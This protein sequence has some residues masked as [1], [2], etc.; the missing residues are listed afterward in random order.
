[1]SFFHISLVSIPGHKNHWS[2]SNFRTDFN[3]NFQL[4]HSSP[5]LVHLAD[6]NKYRPGPSR[7]RTQAAMTTHAQR[8]TCSA[9]LTLGAS[10]TV[11]NRALHR[12]YIST[13]YNYIT[14]VRF[15][16]IT[17]VLGHKKITP[18]GIIVENI[19]TNWILS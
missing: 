15:W 7:D 1:M 10:T 18:F 8:Q 17:I 6:I 19:M 2:I 13:C 11:G 14:H 5:S 4:L 12:L 3:K 9:I 16:L